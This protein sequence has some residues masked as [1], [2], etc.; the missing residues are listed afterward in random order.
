MK[1]KI[2][3]S[4]FGKDTRVWLDGKEITSAVRAVKL[5]WEVGLLNRVSIELLARDLEIETEG[6]TQELEA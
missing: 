3:S 5:H 1:I 6:Y 2:F 4:K